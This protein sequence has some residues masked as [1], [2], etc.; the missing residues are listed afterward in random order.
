MEIHY[1]VPFSVINNASLFVFPDVALVNI[2]KNYKDGW[3][4]RLI[5]HL[6]RKLYSLEHWFPKCG[7]RNPGGS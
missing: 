1:R 3:C 2:K 6:A 7:L 5:F 4:R